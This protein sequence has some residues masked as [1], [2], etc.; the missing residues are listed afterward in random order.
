MATLLVASRHLGHRFVSRSAQ[1]HLRIVMVPFSLA[2]RAHAMTVP[3]SF[4]SGRLRTCAQRI[5]RPQYQQHVG[6]L[7]S[8]GYPPRNSSMSPSPASMRRISSRTFGILTSAPSGTTRG[9]PYI[10]SRCPG[11][12]S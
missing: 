1:Y 3:G 2:Q 12:P 11:V 4:G 7:R 9:S 5:G 6:R 10:A 8:I